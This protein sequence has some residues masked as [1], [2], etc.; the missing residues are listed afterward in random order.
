MPVKQS[1]KVI[2]ALGLLMANS[3]EQQVNALQTEAKAEVG[4]LMQN[5]VDVDQTGQAE[6]HHKKKHHRS[7]RGQKKMRKPRGYLSIGNPEEDKQ[8]MSMVKEDLQNS[9]QDQEEEEQQ[10]QA[11]QQ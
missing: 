3:G 6:K 9:M 7:H 4:H 10:E 2:T 11:D 5:A 1:L 8:A